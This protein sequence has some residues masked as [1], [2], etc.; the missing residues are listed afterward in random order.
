MQRARC[1]PVA[2]PLGQRPWGDGVAFEAGPLD[3]NMPAPQCPL[4]A[5]KKSVFGG[6]ANRPT[7]RRYL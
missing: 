2:K 4:D 3:D 6:P 1:V 5:V 7:S